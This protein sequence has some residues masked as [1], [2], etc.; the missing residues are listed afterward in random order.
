MLNS[1]IKQKIIKAS[2]IIVFAR[3]KEPIDV[4]YFI[5]NFFFNKK[6]LTGSPPT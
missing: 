6:A 2:K 1:P 3:I 4:L 5:L